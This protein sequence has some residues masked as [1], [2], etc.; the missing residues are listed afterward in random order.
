MNALRK[1]AFQHVESE[2]YAYPETR[3]EIV[4]L[5]AEIIA[6]YK[7]PDENIGGG[8][9]DRTGDPTGQTAVLLVTN[10]RLEQLERIADAIETV[11]NCLPAERQKLVR[12]K[13]WTK[14]QTLTWEGIAR[15][16]HI[17]RRQAFNWRDQ[18]V[19][20]IGSRLGW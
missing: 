18:A 3:R 9:S 15:E 2:L 11:Y 4:R 8:R 7:E 13:Y 14:P 1:G 12:L 5:K 10:R 19:R 6:G 20:V 17:S 16:L